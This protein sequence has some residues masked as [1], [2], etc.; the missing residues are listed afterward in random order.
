L[1]ANPNGKPSDISR[2]HD[3]T[4]PEPGWWDVAGGK[5][6][7]YRL[8]AEQTV[9]GIVRELKVSAPPCRTAHE[10]L[11]PH[12]EIA[13]VSGILPSE[14]SRRSVEHYCARE[15]AV[16][17][18]DVMVRRTSWHYYF[19]DAAK[20]AERVADWMGELLGWSAEHRSV[21]LQRYYAGM[22]YPC[23]NGL[24]GTTATQNVHPAH[25]LV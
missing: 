2:S 1:I 16:H 14:F 21:E 24:P 22:N 15:W 10:P 5:L 25:P 19:R 12:A 9:D 11:L 13:G 17:L 18:D 4:R 23:L 7:T 20:K 6:T 3:I 8:M